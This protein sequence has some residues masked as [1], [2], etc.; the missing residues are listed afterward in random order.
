MRSFTCVRCAEIVDEADKR[1]DTL[2]HTSTCPR[3][4]SV[5]LTWADFERPADMRGYPT[6][7]SLRRIQK[8]SNWIRGAMFVLLGLGAVAT[9]QLPPPRGVGEPVAG[10][11]AVIAG[12]VLLGMGVYSLF[13]RPRRSRTERE[14]HDDLTRGC[15]GRRCAPPLNRQ[16]ASRPM[17]IGTLT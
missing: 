13:P 11:L 14:S 5:N 15:S 7:E 1:W 4:G 9:R 8:R 6:T 16:V 3:C 2:K 17:A 12:G 10:F